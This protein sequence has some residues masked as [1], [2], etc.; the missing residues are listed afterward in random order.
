MAQFTFTVPDA[1]LA[2]VVDALCGAYGYQ[3]LLPD[4][5]PNP[6]TRQQFAREQVRRFMQAAVVAWEA[7]IAGDDAA[8]VARTK[9]QQEVTIT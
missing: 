5:I 2:R 8:E 7:R 9:A 6:Q 3:P 4:N 1:Q